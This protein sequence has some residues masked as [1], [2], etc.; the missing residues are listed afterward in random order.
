MC[1]CVCVCVC[2][3]AFD[4]S[5]SSQLAPSFDSL[6]PLPVCLDVPSPDATLLLP[7]RCFAASV[8]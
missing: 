6:L 8:P 1:E 7:C 5:L 3:C 2:V 4:T